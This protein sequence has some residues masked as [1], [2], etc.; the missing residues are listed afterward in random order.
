MF[1][2]WEICWTS[3]AFC[4]QIMLCFETLWDILDLWF[5]TSTVML[6]SSEASTWFLRF[7][8]ALMLWIK[9]WRLWIYRVPLVRCHGTFLGDY[10]VSYHSALPYFAM[11]GEFT[12]YCTMSGLLC[13]AHHP[14]K[15]NTLIFM[16]RYSVSDDLEA[17][18]SW[19]VV[20]IRNHLYFLDGKGF[21]AISIQV[22]CCFSLISALLLI[23]WL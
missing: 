10:L 18:T 12:E 8:I 3:T 7:R 9:W 22:Y 6:L 20:S 1:L 11:S 14:S 15:Y 19:V 21:R 13:A 2:G 5:R 4:C 16:T 23:S 17:Y